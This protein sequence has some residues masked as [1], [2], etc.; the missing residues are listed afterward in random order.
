LI[1][2]PCYSAT[3]FAFYGNDHYL[4][5]FPNHNLFFGDSLVQSSNTSL[6]SPSACF[7]ISQ[8]VSSHSIYKPGIT[9]TIP[10][11]N[12]EFYKVRSVMLICHVQTSHQLIPKIQQYNQAGDH[13]QYLTCTLQNKPP[14]HPFRIQSFAPRSP[15][16][17]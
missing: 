6:G 12:L 4:R 8:F 3:K 16:F 10:F 15:S 7:L 2:V 17:H 14:L 1:A 5:T 9:F 11:M 13:Y